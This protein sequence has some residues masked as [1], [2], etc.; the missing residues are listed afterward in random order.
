MLCC[1]LLDYLW[2]FNTNAKPIPQSI[3]SQSNSNSCSGMSE[4]AFHFGFF[5]TKGIEQK[6]FK[7]ACVVPCQQRTWEGLVLGN[8][9]PPTII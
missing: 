9:D 4:H 1:F 6:K 7:V 2:M 3:C 5:Q 8:A